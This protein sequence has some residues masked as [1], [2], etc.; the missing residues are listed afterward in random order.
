MKRCRAAGDTIGADEPG[1]VDLNAPA[2]TSNGSQLEG[3]LR[4]HGDTILYAALDTNSDGL[5]ELYGYVETNNQAGYQLADREVF[6]LAPS[7]G[8]DGHSG[9]Y[10]LTMND[11]VDLP[12]QSVLLEFTNIFS[13]NQIDDRLAILDSPNGQSNL[14]ISEVVP[15]SKVADSASFVGIHNNVMNAG[16][17][18]RYEFGTVDLDSNSPTFSLSPTGT[19]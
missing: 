7:T 6:T 1:Q 16:E 17:Q 8:A 2:V 5:E 15:D 18:I 3:G 14:L 9:D 4:S 19:P 10:T 13:P 12:V 11:V